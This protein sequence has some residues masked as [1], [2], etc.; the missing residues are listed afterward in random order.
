MGKVPYTLLKPIGRGHKQNAIG[1]IKQRPKYCP[2][3]KIITSNPNYIPKN[4]IAKPNWQKRGAKK[5]SQKGKQDGGGGRDRTDDLKL[6]K[7]PLSQ[8]SYAPIIN[9]PNKAI[10]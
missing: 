6:A 1:K 4:Q 10:P 5:G 8:L 9:A 7:L 2:S 3:K